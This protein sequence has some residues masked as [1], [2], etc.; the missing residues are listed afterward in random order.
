MFLLYYILYIYNSFWFQILSK[1]FKALAWVRQMPATTCIISDQRSVVQRPHFQI[2]GQEVDSHRD[3]F[4]CNWIPIDIILG[5]TKGLSEDS[6]SF[7]IFFSA[8]LLSDGHF[9]TFLFNFIWITSEQVVLIYLFLPLDWMLTLPACEI[10][11]SLVLN[12][13]W[14]TNDLYIFK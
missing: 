4:T 1:P 6:S 12:V 7:I 14:V 3:I 8:E 13:F 2:K 10:Y 5:I 11:L 9:I